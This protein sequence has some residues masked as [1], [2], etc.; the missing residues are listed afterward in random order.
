MLLLWLLLPRRAVPA[1][2]LLLTTVGHC[3]NRTLNERLDVTMFNARMVV[4][5]TALYSTTLS[6]HLRPGQE[7]CVVVLVDK[8][9]TKWA[10]NYTRN[11]FIQ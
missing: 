3:W 8:P 5:R 11:L 9:G 1:S 2:L 6:F 4:P 10:A 7:K